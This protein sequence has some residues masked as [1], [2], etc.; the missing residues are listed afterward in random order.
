MKLAAFLRSCVFWLLFSVGILVGAT[1]LLIAIPFAG[2]DARYRIV[3]AWCRFT[4]NCMSLI[5]GAKF[6][7][8]DMDRL[9]E[10]GPLILLSKHQSGWETLAFTAFIPRKLT[11]VYKKELH[12]IPV[13]G[14]GLASLKMFCIDRSRGSA[15]YEQMKKRAPDFL[16]RGWVFVLF[17]EGT[18]T[19]PGTTVKYKS[20]GARIAID[21]NTPIIPVAL[22]SGEIWPKGSFIIYPGKINVV[23]GPEIRPENK[24]VA[25]LNNEVQGWIE[26]RMREISPK[27]YK[28][29][30][31]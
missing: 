1:I 31:Q 13:F 26:N 6:S 30:S 4:I 24:T 8:A 28:Q 25:Q 22:N 21:T 16:K 18:R 19:K 15:A 23:F 9:A 7:F 10:A 2:Q 17:P 29:Q 12:K 20:G 27:Y 14:W 11:F 5:C 3:K